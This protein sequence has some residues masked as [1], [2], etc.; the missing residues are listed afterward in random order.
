MQHL[1]AEMKYQ[2]TDFYLLVE[3]EFCFMCERFLYFPFPVFYI[4]AFW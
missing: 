4:K 3:N 2:Y 1:T